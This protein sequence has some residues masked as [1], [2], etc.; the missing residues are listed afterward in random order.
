[1]HWNQ[2]QSDYPAIADLLPQNF[3]ADAADEN[4]LRRAIEQDRT[5]YL[6]ILDTLAQITPAEAIRKDPSRLT[7]KTNFQSFYAEM[8]AYVAL[9]HWVFAPSPADIHGTSGEPD[10][11]STIGRLDIE[12]AS[13]T[14]WDK[15][16]NV[17]VALEAQLDDTP[18]TAIITL[19][20]DFI[21]IPYTGAD[22]DH[23][24][25]LVDDIIDEIEQLDTSNLPASISNQGFRIE[26]EQT[27]GGGAIIRWGQAEQIPLDP[28]GRIADQL[29]DKVKKQRGGRPLLLFYDADVSFLE[30]EDIKDLL[31]GVPSSGPQKEVSDTVYQHRSVWGDYLREQGYIPDSGRT[32]YMRQVAPDDPKYDLKHVGDS[33]I[34]SGDG[35]L[36]A[37]RAFDRVA[38]V[39]FIDKPGYGHFFPNFY[40]AKLNF[41]PVYETVSQNMEVRSRKFKDLL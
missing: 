22:I 38:G 2:F 24:E 26:F 41:H 17:R 25:Q 16:D 5:D 3:M 31:H 23:N 35:G 20:D 12:V 8:K 19:R 7:S 1:M 13:R 11:E 4:T 28:D 15:K 30:A 33:C 27:G 6:A 14:A 34:C 18:Y 40:S 36:F 21:K 10:Y 29:T 9:K 37:D 39:S 32:T